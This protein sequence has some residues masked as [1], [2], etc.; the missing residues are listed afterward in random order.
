MGTWLGSSSGLRDAAWTEELQAQDSPRRM[1]QGCLGQWSACHRAF[2]ALCVLLLQLLAR[3][4]RGEVTLPAGDE[5]QP[6]L[7]CS[8]LG[9]GVA[10]LLS[11]SQVLASV[12]M[13]VGCDM[14]A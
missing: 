6:S 3:D 5:H 2:L 4:L 13:C 11:L 1:P 12:C 10:Q 9:R 8:T 7:T 14:G